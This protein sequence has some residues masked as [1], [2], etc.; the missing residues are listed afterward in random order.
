MWSFVYLAL[1]RMVDLVL[2]CFRSGDAKEVEILVLRHELEILR[3]QHRR[4]SLQPTDRAWLALLSRILPRAR[5]SVFVVQPKT[6]LGWH[7]L[8]GPTTGSSA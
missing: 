8:K 6:L 1:R 4:P 5:W 2:L 7:R 3:R